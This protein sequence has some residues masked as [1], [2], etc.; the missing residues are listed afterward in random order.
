MNGKY[1]YFCEIKFIQ[2]IMSI[3]ILKLSNNSLWKMHTL[4]F[5]PLQDSK[6]V[7]YILKFVITVKHLQGF[8][9]NFAGDSITFRYSQDSKYR[10]RTKWSLLEFLLHLQYKKKIIRGLTYLPSELSR[11]LRFVIKRHSSALLVYRE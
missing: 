3:G 9:K 2:A 7:L 5:S 8:V 1:R 6:L 4:F 10:T 11:S